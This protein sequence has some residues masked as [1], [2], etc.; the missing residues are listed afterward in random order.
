MYKKLPGDYFIKLKEMGVKVKKF[1]HCKEIDQN[2]GAYC[3]WEDK[4]IAFAELDSFVFAHELGHTLDML[5]LNGLCKD[6]NLLNIFRQE[7][8][9]YKLNSSATE[10]HFIDYFTTLNHY[11]DEGCIVEVIAETNALLSG[12]SNAA[13]TSTMLGLRSITLQQHFPETIAYIAQKLI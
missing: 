2:G 10:G 11:L 6:K 7:L 8:A 9:R 13:S 4:L 3:S 5:Y 12:L 1:P